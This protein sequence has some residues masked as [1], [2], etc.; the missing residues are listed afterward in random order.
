MAHV[1]VPEQPSRRIYE[2]TTSQDTFTFP[3]TFYEDSDIEVYDKDVSETVPLSSSLYTV[4][5]NAGSDEGYEGGNV[6]LNTGVTNTTV[7][8]RLNIPIKRTS[9]HKNSSEFNI[10]ELNTQTDKQVSMLQKLES[11][12]KRS[13]KLRVTSEL[14]DGSGNEL[15]LTFLEDPEES[16][17]FI[18]DATQKGFVNGPATTDIAS[19]AASIDNVDLI[20]LYIANVNNVGNSISDV[21]ALAAVADD[22]PVL[23]AIPADIS[24]VA[25]DSDDIQLLADLQDGTVATGALSTL[26]GLDTEMVAL[27]AISANITATAGAITNINAVGADLLGDDDIGTCATNIAAINDVADALAAAVATGIS[28]SNGSSPLSSFKAH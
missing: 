23:A 19:V 9:D 6:V 28:Y 3:F 10:T 13:L 25:D 15:D 20:A 12:L 16:K 22:I 21:N 1:T 2:V 18:Y 5:G 7:I 24:Q 8:V 26:A 11:L 4:N 27:A 14:V 17:V